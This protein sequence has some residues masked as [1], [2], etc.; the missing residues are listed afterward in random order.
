MQQKLSR[1]FICRRHDVVTDYHNPFSGSK[2]LLCLSPDA[3]PEGLPFTT[4]VCV[5]KEV[6]Q[7]GWENQRRFSTCCG[8]SIALGIADIL[9]I[10]KIFEIAFANKKS[11]LEPYTLEA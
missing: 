7:E 3:I 2:S 9:R 11:G 6:F 10:S 8:N 1:S 5:V 4:E